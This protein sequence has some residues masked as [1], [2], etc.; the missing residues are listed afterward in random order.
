MFG[1]SRSPI[2]REMIPVTSFLEI[3]RLLAT[4]FIR[5]LFINL[6]QLSVENSTFDEILKKA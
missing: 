5:S 2:S 6:C 1:L 3:L 4:K